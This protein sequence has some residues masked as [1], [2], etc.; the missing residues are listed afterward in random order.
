MRKHCGEEVE[1]LAIKDGTCPTC[2]KVCKSSA[3]LLYHLSTGC[4]K[5]P[6]E[7]QG[8]LTELMA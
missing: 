2:Q 6:V 7:K 4:I 1:A 5:F 3:A 8:F